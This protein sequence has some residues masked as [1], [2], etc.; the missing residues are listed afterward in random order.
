MV[1]S[2]WNKLKKPIFVLAPMANVTDVAFRRLIA[3]YGKPDVTWTEFVSCDGLMSKGREHLLIDLAYDESERPI[4]A[5]IFGSK[6][7]NFFKTAQLLKEMGFDGIDINM[8][9]PDKN[10]EKQGAG[11]NMMKNPKLAQ[12]VILATKEGSGGLPV[13]V[14][15][16]IGYSKNMLSE[17]LPVL[18]E[19]KLAAITVHARTRKEMSLVPARWEHLKEAVEIRDAFDNSS[20]KTLILGNGDVKNLTEAYQRVEE[21]GCDGVMIGRGVFGN[22]W[23]FNREMIGKEVS[24]QQ[25]LKV[26]IEHTY[27]FEKLLTAHKD[28]NIMKKHYKAYVNGFDNAKELRIE[29]MENAVDASAVEK[30][31]NEFIAK[32]F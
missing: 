29:L 10:V 18:F 17:W 7:E 13:S 20:N 5:Q 25:K 27:L 2:F 30:I 14:K 21:T 16:R 24:V 12:E 11:A 4:V 8:G 26:M 9:C 32:N 31:T 19:T 15:T 23:V 6:P 22:P 1:E 3:K 28:F